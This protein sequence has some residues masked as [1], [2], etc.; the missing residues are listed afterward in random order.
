MIIKIN[1][2]TDVDMVRLLYAA[3]QAG[4]SIDLIVRGVCCLRPGVPGVS[5]HIRVRSIVG[6]FLEHSR[7]F[8]FQN[9]G[10][11]RVWI[12][13]ADLMERNL[14]R[15]VETLCP[16]L[17]ADWAAHLRDVVLSALLKDNVRAHELQANG[18]YRLVEP[19]DGETPVDSQQELLTW[20]LSQGREEL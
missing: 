4:V 14:D 19:A 13:S 15:R 7:I 6:R 1:A 18:E 16:I 9:G 8:W 12:G 11:P 3:S 2:L 17:D 5:E 10:S 20:Y